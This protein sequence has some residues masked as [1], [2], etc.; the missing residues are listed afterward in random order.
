MNP[1][2]KVVLITLCVVLGVG[3]LFGW[4]AFVVSSV[5]SSMV[6]TQNRYDYDLNGESAKV[7][8]SCLESGDTTG[9]TKVT[10]DTS[11]ATITRTGD[12]TYTYECD[13]S[14]DTQ[15][16]SGERVR[17]TIHIR[18]SMVCSN[19]GIPTVVDLDWDDPTKE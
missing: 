10:V 14:W 7:L 2:K 11:S 13:T 6:T 3:A 9:M 16:D 1:M 8:E 18:A 15:I 5:V 12:N 17:C 4:S 19:H